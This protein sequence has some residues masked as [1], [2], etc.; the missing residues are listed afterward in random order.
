[1]TWLSYTASDEHKQASCAPDA[2]NAVIMS[3]RLLKPSLVTASTPPASKKFLAKDA[4]G[5]NSASVPRLARKIL[6]RAPVAAT[7]LSEASR[8]VSNGS[9]RRCGFSAG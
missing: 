9:A 4:R 7:A 1:M 5:V 3:A 8:K 2:L 6:G